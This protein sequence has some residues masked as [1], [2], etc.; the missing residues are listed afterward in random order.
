MISERTER[1]S[2]FLREAIDAEYFSNKLE[3]FQ[4]VTYYLKNED[5]RKK[6]A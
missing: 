5:K 4:K 6:I 2:S 3:L 1:Q